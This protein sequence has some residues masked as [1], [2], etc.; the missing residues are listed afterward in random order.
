MVQV[1][2]DLERLDKVI[3]G[4]LVGPG[5]GKTTARIFEA[6]GYVMTGKHPQILFLMSKGWDVE[7]LVPMFYSVF[8]GHYGLELERIDRYKLKCM[9]SIIRFFVPDM[10]GR[11]VET[12]HRLA[13]TGEW[14]V[15][16]M[17]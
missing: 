7:W 4:E 10:S 6:A 16:W 14:L 11:P 3:R 2:Y 17:D 1:T 12:D 9:E 13:G 5:V 15:I 8:E